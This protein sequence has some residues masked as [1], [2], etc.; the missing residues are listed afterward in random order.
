MYLDQYRG[1]VKSSQA[2]VIFRVLSFIYGHPVYLWFTRLLNHL[3]VLL[4]SVKE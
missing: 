1:K 4:T 2:E 3:A